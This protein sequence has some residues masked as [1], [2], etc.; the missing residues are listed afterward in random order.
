MSDTDRPTAGY[1]CGACGVRHEEC[2][3]IPPE[4]WA[5]YISPTS[6]DRGH[7]CLQ[8]ADTMLRRKG[9]KLTW[10]AQSGR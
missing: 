4:I 5:E 6:D 8:C 3:L 1:V 9:F 2:F 10:M 7:C